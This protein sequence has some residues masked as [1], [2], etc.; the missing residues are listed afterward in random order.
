MIK[1]TIAALL[2]TVIAAPYAYADPP[3]WAPAHGWREKHDH[4]EHHRDEYYEARIY[5]PMVAMPWR[6][7]SPA[8]YGIDHGTCRR[9]LLG[10]V[11]GGGTGALL[12]STIGE[13][14]GKLVAVAGGAILGVLAGGAIGRSMD[15]VDQ[16]CIGQALEHAPNGQRIAWSSPDGGPAYTV[17][18]MQTYAMP[19]GRYCREYTTNARIGGRTQQTYGRACR[20]PDGSWQIVN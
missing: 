1:K 8:P 5:Q 12:G 11:L 18:P 3:P 4:H 7:E 13:G 16:N 20:Q 14:T 6:G 15:E 9:D 10:A 17:V 19:D 2:A